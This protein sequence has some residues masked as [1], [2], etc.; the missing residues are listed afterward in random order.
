MKTAIAALICGALFGFGL[1]LARMTDPVVVLGFHDVFDNFDPTLAFVLVG[2]AATTAVAFRLVLR[3][4]RPILAAEFRLPPTR[5]ID[6]S[7]VAGAAIFGAGWGLA[8]YCPGPAIVGAG[9]GVTT[10]L[11]FLPAMLA[12]SVLHRLF[13]A[14][15]RSNGLRPNAT[16][17]PGM[18]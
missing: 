5:A 16:S 4:L 14:N 9:G 15:P 13:A 11:L 17:T 3:R 1:V 18:R 12:G 2:A 7:L 6:F 10:A 8:G